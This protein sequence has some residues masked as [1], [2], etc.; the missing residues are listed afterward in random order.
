MP[1]FTKD[2]LSKMNV[3]KDLSSLI[4]NFN[5]CKKLLEK[6]ESRFFEE[7]EDIDLVTHSYLNDEDKQ[8]E[9]IMA[10]VSAINEVFKYI[11]FVMKTA[12]GDLIGYWH[13]PENEE[14]TKSPIVLYDTEGQFSILNG[15]NLSEALVGNYVFDEDDEFLEFQKRFKDC[16]IKIVS[17][18]D[19]LTEPKPKASPK[20]IHEKQY[21]ASKQKVSIKKSIDQLEKPPKKHKKPSISDK[22]II[23]LFICLPMIGYGLMVLLTGKVIRT[24]Y[25]GF[26]FYIEILRYPIGIIILAFSLY[27][28]YLLLIKKNK[29]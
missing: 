15:S 14:I 9:D 10:N 20:S 29:N 3:P 26:S 4:N 17:K 27:I 2:Q 19:D 28:T 7:D 18:W 16:G 22:V 23:F 12:N 8:N 24:K 21:E 25:D 1:T 5:C 11:S 13:G 6:M